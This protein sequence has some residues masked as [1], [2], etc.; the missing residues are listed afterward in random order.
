MKIPLKPKSSRR[1]HILRSTGRSAMRICCMGLMDG[2][3]GGV[4]VGAGGEGGAAG[5]QG[6]T[7]EKRRARNN[8]RR[9]KRD[10]VGCYNLL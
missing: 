2:F 1:A 6:R 8:S 10:G 5:A 4:G 9:A 3:E 7:Q